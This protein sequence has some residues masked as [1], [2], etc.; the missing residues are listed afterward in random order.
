[1]NVLIVEDE[2]EIQNLIKV[3]LAPYAACDTA[4]DGEQGLKKFVSHLRY[5]AK[6]DLILLDIMLPRLDG[7]GLL[8]RIRALEAEKGIGRLEGV[9]I[10]MLTALD[11]V[12]NVIGS[13]KTGCD[14]YVTKPFDPEDLIKE[15]KGVGLLTQAP[16]G[17]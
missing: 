9:K 6:Y 3:I 8:N 13:F 14:S 15:I 11:D 1:M 4:N 7:K 5:G 12:K 10:I 2:V 17:G 16:P